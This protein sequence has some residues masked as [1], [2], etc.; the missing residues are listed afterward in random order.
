[1]KKAVVPPS[2]KPHTK[3]PEKRN[4]SMDATLPMSNSKKPHTKHS[5]KRMSSIFRSMSNLNRLDILRVLYT[6]GSTS[7]TDLK[8]VA[9]FGTKKDS[10]KFAYHLRDLTQLAL[11]ER[12]KTERR[13]TITTQGKIVLEL[14]DRIEDNA[15]R[16]GGKLRVRS[17]H[18]YDEFKRQRIVQSLV[19]EGDVPYELA[20]KITKEVESKIYRNEISYVTGALIREVA[21]TVLLETNHEEYRNKLMRLGMPIYDVQQMLS[22]L[23]QV[24]GGM[25]DLIIKAGRNV[26]TENVMFGALQ[27]DM[28]DKHMSGALHISNIETW[29]T[30]PDV[31][32]AN[33]RELLKNGMDIGGKHAA[34]SRIPK[35]RQLSDVMASLSIMIQLLSK[36]VSE[37]VVMAGLPQLIAEKCAESSDAEIENSLAWAFATASPASTLMTEEGGG[38]GASSITSIR[39]NLGSYAGIV[40]CIINAYEEYVRITPKPRVG[41]IIGYEK[42]GIESVSAQIARIVLLGGRVLF[43]KSPQ[44]SGR[45]VVGGGPGKTG[46]AI[47]ISLMSVSVNLPGLAREVDP[48]EADLFIA[49]LV[50]VIKP[51]VEALILRKRGIFEATH[52]GLNPQIARHTLYMQR[53]HASMIINLVGLNESVFDNLGFKYDRRGREVIQKIIRHAVEAGAVA[54]KAVDEKVAI[55]MVS[56]EG[57]GRLA[58]LDDKR[59]GRQTLDPGGAKPYSQGMT[60]AAS[61]LSKYTNKSPPITLYNRISRSLNAG[62]QVKLKV[63]KEESDPAVVKS[64]LEKMVTLIPSFMPVKEIAVCA[65]CGFKDRPFEAKCPKC[66]MPRPAV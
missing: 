38:E 9:G 48:G 3:H 39:L 17:S 41:L 6:K 28:A 21:N 65:K 24:D 60:F 30:L 58:R 26:F 54:A 4:R 5:E 18:T 51:I 64:A 44:V 42:D 27:K 14:A 50:L 45:G 10:G 36:E 49:R 25:E 61:E 56:S 22:N 40:K 43:T 2:K 12:N 29:F 47:S 19:K 62:L 63:P 20:E 7:Y 11:V 23:D 13:Y 35:P 16:E 52:R 57:A 31:M 37:E 8:H 66:Q 15:F 53:A 55:C 59:Y 33:I 32:F 46:G 1:M 34:T